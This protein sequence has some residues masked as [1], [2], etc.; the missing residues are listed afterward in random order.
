MSDYARANSGGATHFTDKDGLSTGDANKL[1]VGSEHDSEFNAILTAANSKYDSD[2]I[3]SQA[4]AEAGSSNTKVMTPLRVQNWGDANSG[5]VGDLQALADPNADTLFGWDDSAGAG[6]GFTA[7]TGMGFST[8]TFEMS[9]LGFED[10]VDPGADRIAFWDDG[11]SKFDWLVPGD[12]IEISG[13]NLQLP[14]AVAGAGLTLTSGV[15]AVVGGDGITANANDIELTAAGAS[16]T[17]PVDIAS[18]VV[19][20][21][22]EA[23]TT[24]EGNA[25][26]ATDTFYVEDGG[27]SKGIEVQAAGLRVQTGQATQTLAAADMNS[28]M[29]F[30]ATATLTLP[31]NA[32][33]ALP[34]GVPIVL[35]V[36]HATQVLTV[37]ADTSV[38]LVSIFHPGG[39]SAASDVVSAGGS[40]L[41]YKT[42]ADVWALTG[43]I[44]DS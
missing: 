12:G 9:H 5:A 21:D 44:V 26:A 43:N 40:A 17:N 24:I 16:T 20:L 42:A 39:G 3:A 2:D 38:T 22:V 32:T 28:I 7:G 41:L 23:L 14:A 11:A 34:V 31:L 29:E 33:A 35:N 27:V 10:L 1:I 13:T 18:G 8:T 37:T 4:E 6:I 36:K 15:L 25:L 19:S 30:T